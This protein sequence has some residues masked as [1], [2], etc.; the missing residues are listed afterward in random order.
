[1][2]KDQVQI[3]LYF[4]EISSKIWYMDITI[5]LENQKKKKNAF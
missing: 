5:K 1:M 2:N 3:N 4:F